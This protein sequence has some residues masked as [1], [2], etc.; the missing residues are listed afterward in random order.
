MRILCML[1]I[2]LIFSAFSWAE[3]RPKTGVF[4]LTFQER[5]PE[6]AYE[7]MAQRYGWGKADA[8]AS[9]DIATEP[10]D[11]NVPADYDGTAAYG[12]IVYTDPGQSGNP[13]V[14]DSVLQKHKLIW[15]GASNVPNERNV[16]PRWGLS[17]DAVWNMRKRYNIDPKRIYACGMSG[18]GRCA[19]MVAPT[20]ADV[21]SGGIYLVGCNSPVFPNEQAV[22]KPIRELAKANRYALMT[23]SGDMNKPGTKQVFDTYQSIGMKLSIY[24]EEPGLGHAHPS[25]A[26]FTKGLEFCDQP[27][28][29][30]ADEIVAQAKKIE[31]KKPYEAC[32]AYRRVLTGY[33]MA[34]AAR[35]TAKERFS[36]LSSQADEALRAEYAKLDKAPKDKLR[37]FVKRAEGFPC[38]DGAI[39]QADGLASSELDAVLAAPGAMTASKLAKFID[40]WHGYPTANRALEAYEA[41]AAKAL[42]PVTALEPGKREKG[43]AKFLKEWTECP[44]RVRAMAA[45]ETD[46]RTQL[47]TIEAIDKIQSRG[48]KLV[49]FIKEWPGTAAAARAEQSLKAITS[50]TD[51]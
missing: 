42:E 4:K 28:V 37:A 26:W 30:E 18:G 13:M 45:L 48:Q 15:I 27:L 19:S 14:Y 17:L 36:A 39:T 31:A 11:V 23:G 38:A 44:S 5:H 49:A 16:V 34:E 3:D 25:A 32:V 21:F 20:Y 40:E 35:S 46:L 43:L 9:Y 7:R 8:T 24:L 1:G 29:A 22:G 47:D 2:S 10:F 12:L 51:K 50:S 41:L 33:I 6:S